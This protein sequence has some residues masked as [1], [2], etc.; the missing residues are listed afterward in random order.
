MITTFYDFIVLNENL[1]LA[2]KIYFKTGIL[3][4]DDKQEIINITHSDNYTK[5]IADFYEL[6]KYK[7]KDYDNKTK[8]ELLLLYNDLKE[9]NKNVYPIKGFYDINNID[10]DT[11]TLESSLRYR[12]DILK[13]FKQLPSIASRNMKADIRIERSLYELRTYKDELE[14]VLSR[15]S[16]ISNRDS[17]SQIKILQKIFKNNTSISKISD[18]LDDKINLIG[19]KEITKEYIVGL[20]EQTD[21]TV[22]YDK[23][24]IMIIKV[25][26]Q[27]AIK[28]LGCNSLWCFTYGE[29]GSRAS[30]DWFN[31]SH[32]GL[33]YVLVDFRL[34]PDNE[35]FMHVVISPLL[36]ENGRIIKYD[37]E[38]EDKQPIF[39]MSNENYINPYSIL[40][41]IFGKS[42]RTI[43]K[44]YLNFE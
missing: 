22:I 44:K 27:D 3:N 8:S 11:N 32:D 16:L 10:I 18:F 13:L 20:Q 40:E 41:H 5:I 30:K 36:D 24:D 39:N 19:G 21:L 14:S 38:N 17:R 6:F 33:V 35:E 1:Q 7:R 34:P 12:R 42:Y 29:I 2:D 28:L 43:I 23:N 15:L 9:Y 37:D 4:E 26:S 25:E 31:Y